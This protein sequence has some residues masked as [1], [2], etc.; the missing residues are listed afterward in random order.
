MP[1][2][3][4]AMG[5]RLPGLHSTVCGLG[6]MFALMPC[7]RFGDCLR[8]KAAVPFGMENIV[9]ERSRCCCC[10]SCHGFLRSGSNPRGRESRGGTGRSWNGKT[11]APRTLG[12]IGAAEAGAGALTRFQN[13]LVLS[14]FPRYPDFR[15]PHHR[16]AGR[17]RPSFLPENVGAL[18]RNGSTLAMRHDPRCKVVGGRVEGTEAM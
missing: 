7:D 18:E 6:G 10:R 4:S 13:P 14:V 16:T 15:D 2:R 3:P 9:C 8:G 12:A 17:I 11:I 1:A 5:R